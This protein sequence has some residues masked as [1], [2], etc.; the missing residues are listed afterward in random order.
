M[1]QNSSTTAKLG[2]IGPGIMGQPM[3]LNL[4]KAGHDVAVY[5]RTVSRTAPLAAAGAQVCVS[6]AEVA[7]AAD[8]IFTCV[9]DTPDVE[10]VIFGDQGII[11]GARQ[12]SVVVDMSTI[13]PDATRD[14]AACLAAKGID[15]LD[16]PV[17][18]GESGAI[19]GT[20]SIMVGGKDD[21]FAR[22]KPYFDAMGKN[23]VHVGGNGAG[24]V[25][26]SCNQIV[27]AVTIE[28]V[29]EA[30]LLAEKSGVDGAK[31]RAALLGGFA[32][33]K[34]LEVHGNRMLN[35][36]YKPG[37]KT[38]LHRKDMG[39]VL[40]TAQRLGLMLPGAILVTGHLDAVLA[41]G[42]G[43]QDSS[44]IF[45]ALKRE[46]DKNPQKKKVV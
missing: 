1:T 26:K 20:L 10:A 21:V 5:G 45:K 34:I 19:A 32:G 11:H 7:A 29:A 6:P 8:I 31:V 16:A 39:I 13:S 43:E 42:E 28:A 17:S 30:M 38:A 46:Q 9:S 18:G 36:D 15:M 25:A 33:S 3:V 24:Q 14:F 35:D 23:I 12:G 27:V 41:A 44:A 40:D 37:F 2:F 4:L 22:V